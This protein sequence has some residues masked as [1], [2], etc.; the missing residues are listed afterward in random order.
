MIVIGIAMAV[1]LLCMAD[2]YLAAPEKLPEILLCTGIM[3]IF[4]LINVI[5]DREYEQHVPEEG[6]H[7]EN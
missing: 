4:V 6:L 3:I 1:Y 7:K 5:N 2:L